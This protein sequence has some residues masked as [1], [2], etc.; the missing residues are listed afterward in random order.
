MTEYSTMSQTIALSPTILDATAGQ[1]NTELGKLLQHSIRV[2]TKATQEI[3]G[4][5]WSILPHNL[6]MLPHHLVLTF[7]LCRG[8]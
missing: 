5:G 1:V 7:L 3:E 2:V 6:T 4:S 8:K